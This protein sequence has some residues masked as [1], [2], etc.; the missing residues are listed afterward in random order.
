M[1]DEVINYFR[2]VPHNENPNYQAAFSS[3][4]LIVLLIACMIAALHTVGAVAPE[5]AIPF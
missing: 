3:V 5:V 1:S 2:A 4:L